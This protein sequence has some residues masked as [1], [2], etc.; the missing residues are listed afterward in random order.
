MAAI[1]RQ[2][3]VNGVLHMEDAFGNTLTLDLP[4]LP[5]KRPYDR[6]EATDIIKT[7]IG[8]VWPD[9]ETKVIIE[10]L[11]PVFLGRVEMK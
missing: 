9:I 7:R 6:Q 11:A 1:I 4:S 3:V 2:E 5:L 10:E 8:A